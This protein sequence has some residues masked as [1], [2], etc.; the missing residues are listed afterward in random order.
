MGWMA[1]RKWKEC[2]QQPGT[3][4]PGNMLGCCLIYFHFLW[5]IHPIRPVHPSNG[6]RT[7]SCASHLKLNCLVAEDF[8]R[9]QRI[10]PKLIKAVASLR[11]NKASSQFLH[12]TS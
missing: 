6:I 12:E 3:A 2:K 8:E 10:N 5:A 7:Y 1:Y 11:L 9:I 4:G